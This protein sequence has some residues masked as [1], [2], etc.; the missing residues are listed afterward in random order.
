MRIEFKF[1]PGPFRSYYEFDGIRERIRFDGGF[2]WNF[3][4][5]T[6]RTCA[7]ND[8]KI[9]RKDVEVAFRPAAAGSWFAQNP[10][11]EWNVVDIDGRKWQIVETWKANIWS[12]DWK[13]IDGKLIMAFRRQRCWRGTATIHTDWSENVGL[14]VGMVVPLVLSTG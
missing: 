8:P 2:Y 10:P 11:F 9:Y 6:Y 3:G 14:L 1:N 13:T 7:S 4:G 12:V 5:A